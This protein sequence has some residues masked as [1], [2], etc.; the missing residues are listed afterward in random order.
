MGLLIP[1]FHVTHVDARADLGTCDYGF[2]YLLT[3]LLRESP[4]N[5]HSPRAGDDGLGDGNYL[6]FAIAN[7]WIDELTYVIGGRYEDYMDYP[8]Q[9]G[10]LLPHLF[11]NFDL[12]TRRIRLPTLEA[13]NL[14]ENLCGT[15]R[16]R[17]VALEPPVAFDWSV[18]H[19][20]QATE[21]FDLG[22]AAERRSTSRYVARHPERE[23]HDRQRRVEAAR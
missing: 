15:D 20:Y 4:Q 18:W 5:R 17:P 8:W 13:R 16:L 9:P 3:E 21:P 10:D 6:A 12:S 1:P 2:A 14:R 23:R 19:E 11:E 22:D 7:R